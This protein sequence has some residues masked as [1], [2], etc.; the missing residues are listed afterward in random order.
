MKSSIFLSYPPHYFL[1]QDLSLNLK[2]IGQ[3]GWMANELQGSSCLFHTPTSVLELQM[4]TAVPDFLRAR[5][6]NSGL[7]AASQVLYS[8]NHLPKSVIGNTSVTDLC[9]LR[10]MLFMC[11]Y[12]WIMCVYVQ[13]DLHLTGSYI[14]SFLIQHVFPHCYYIYFYIIACNRTNNCTKR[15]QFYS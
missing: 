1:R 14:S 7:H 3:L 6:R 9:G 12:V 13:I 2:P 11:V 5:D 4:C 10:H 8:S 15:Y